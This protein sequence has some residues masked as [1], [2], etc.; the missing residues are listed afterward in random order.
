[1]RIPPLSAR[2][3]LVVAP[4]PDDEVIAAW[5]LMRR[6]LR[7]GARVEVLVATDGGASHPE[8]R[9]WP[10]PRLV[11]ERRRETRRALRALGIAPDRI[12]FLDLPDGGLLDSP[13]RVRA[14]LSRAMRR[15][16]A[17]QLIVG[18]MPDDAHGDHRAVALALAALPRRGERRLGYRV[19][20]EGAARSLGGLVVPLGLRVAAKRR[21][22]RSYRTQAGRITDAVAGFAMTHHHLRAFAAPAERFAVLA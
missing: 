4:H 9:A 1:V 20:P 18:P 5:G 3:V 7:A 21:A 8:S 10:R 19:W 14:T 16:R 2:R 15:R 17:P 13:D 11:A 12:G 6:L 22:V